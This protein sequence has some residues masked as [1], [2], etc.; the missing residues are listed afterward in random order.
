MAQAAGYEGPFI[1]FDASEHQAIVTA[2][3]ALGLMV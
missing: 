1:G 3:R 2:S